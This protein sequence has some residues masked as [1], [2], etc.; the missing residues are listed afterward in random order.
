MLLTTVDSQRDYAAQQASDRPLTARWTVQI[1]GDAPIKVSE[2]DGVTPV[3]EI[4]FST[5]NVDYSGNAPPP[6]HQIMAKNHSNTLVEVPV[7]S[8]LRDNALPFFV[9]ALGFQSVA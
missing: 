2:A 8:D 4:D 5:T 6:I 7:I 9:R 1:N 3:T